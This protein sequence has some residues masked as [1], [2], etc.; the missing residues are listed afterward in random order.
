MLMDK[1]E[2]RQVT[3]DVIND[4]RLRVTWLMF[5]FALSGCLSHA[6]RSSS[7]SEISSSPSKSLKRGG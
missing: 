5:R 7:N 3:Y 4:A 1:I 6:S 2:R